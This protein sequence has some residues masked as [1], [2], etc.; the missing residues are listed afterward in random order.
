MICLRG[1]DKMSVK[2]IG[3]II[4]EKSSKIKKGGGGED[5]KK[6][7]GFAK[8]L[9]ACIVSVIIEVMSFISNK[10][11]IAVPMLKI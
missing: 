2:D 10:L 8:M 9:P 1:V 11:G 7:T 5:H 3:N 4:K 6:Q